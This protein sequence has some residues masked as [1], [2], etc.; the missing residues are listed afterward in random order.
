MKSASERDREFSAFVSAQRA[1]LV[2][3]AALLL[4]GDRA[5]AEDVVQTALTR[6]YVTW[7]KVRPDTL[8]AYA[9]RS[10]V[11]AVIDDRRKLFRRRERSQAELP[12]VTTVESRD[13]DQ[14]AVIA[15]LSTLPARM[16]A[17][18]VLRYIEGLNAAETAD[19]LGCSEGT[20]RSQSAR[21]LER[22]RAVFPE[23][24]HNFA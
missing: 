19:A 18:V 8:N 6:L 20:V 2:R 1:V 12:D 24:A 17:A 14:T 7:P 11:N 15:L 22:L 9:R 23:H 21:G 3:L 16:R 5:T 10:V 4:T 13:V